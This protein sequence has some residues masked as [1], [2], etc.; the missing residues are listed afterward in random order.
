MNIVQQATSLLLRWLDC[1]A[2]TIVVLLARIITLRTVVLAERAD[3]HFEIAAVGT[4]AKAPGEPIVIADGRVA[5]PLSPSAAAA[6]RGAR[7]NLVLRP[8][9]FLF[10]PLE[11][12]ARAREFLDGIVRSQIDRLTPWSPADASFGWT[13]PADIGNDRVA[14]TVA[15]G[16]RDSVVPYAKAIGAVGARAVTITT[17][18]A[19]GGA[20]DGAITLHEETLSGLLDTRRVRFVLIAILIAAGIGA[21]AAV[22]ADAVLGTQLR[23]RQDDLARRIVARRDAIRAAFTSSGS[24]P[25]ISGLEAL[26]H[27]KREVPASVLVLDEV[28]R[29]LPDD[30]YV[31]EL[32][33][34]GDKLSIIGVSRDAA[35]LIPIIEKSQQFTA[36]KFFAP[37]TRSPSDP[38][39]RFHI[40]AKIAPKFAPRS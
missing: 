25:A 15:A 2:D 29:I 27:R 5:G 28:S 12:P 21:T 10:R 36:A 23:S 1:A 37:T 22:A 24:G 4:D 35:L 11:L 9:R 26:E 8:D 39:E 19:E 40:E 18:F 38:G 30:S 14:L 32:R 34:E 7:V 16:A 6:L 31:T 20:G 17:P 33:I 13:R 3:G